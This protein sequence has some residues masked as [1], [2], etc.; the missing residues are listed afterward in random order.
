VGGK[1]EYS[2]VFID[3]P[4]E[5]PAENHGLSILISRKQQNMRMEC[6]AWRGISSCLDRSDFLAFATQMRFVGM[7]WF[8]S[9][10]GRFAAGI[11]VFNHH[12]QPPNLP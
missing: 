9:R 12:P 4:R 6:P 1:I 5:N 7:P 10:E 2:D 8:R 11:L 3:F